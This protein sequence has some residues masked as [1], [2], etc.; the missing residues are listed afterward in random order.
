MPYGANT[1]SE[2]DTLMNSL[3]ANTRVHLSPGVFKTNGYCDQAPTAGWQPKTMKII[4]AGV[5]MTTL[6]LEVVNPPANAQYFAIGHP[7]ASGTPDT[8]PLLDYFEVSDL[9][10]DCNLT[11]GSPAIACGAVRIKGNHCRVR[12]VKA[13]NWGTKGPACFVLAVITA[14][15]DAAAPEIF[16]AG[17]ED[18]IAVSPYAST[19]GPVTVLHAG[20]K[21]YTNTYLEDFG[22]APYIR[23]CFVDGGSVPLT[24]DMRGLSMGS[25][26]SG[27]VEGNQI[28]NVRYGGPYQD[29]LRDA[30]GILRECVCNWPRG[31]SV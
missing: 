25:C 22:R 24:V 27:I 21:E 12:R 15:P 23:N 31:L 4:G 1:A 16:D 8:S 30:R 17:I 14:D 29:K 10:I 28:H 20:G 13:I 2:F 11:A 7:L 5:D 3:P 18:C 26:R 6:Q 19:L 9:T